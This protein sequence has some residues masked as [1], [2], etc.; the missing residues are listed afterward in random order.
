MLKWICAALATLTLI[1][2][3]GLLACY[4]NRGWISFQNA[5]YLAT[6]LEAIA[7]SFT[8]V[9]I[10]QQLVSQ[11]K[12]L[13]FQ[14]Q[15]AKASNSQSFVHQSSSFMLTIVENHDLAELWR[16]GGAQFETLDASQKMKFKRLVDWWLTFYENVHYQHSC[17]LLDP[18]IFESWENDLKLFIERRQI[19]NVWAD[20]RGS[21]HESF[22]AYVEDFL[23]LEK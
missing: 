2:F 21:Y 22:V 17:D 1:L 9:L 19:T 4:F 20:L 16:V 8:F 11:N 7:V 12:N 6:I 15:L 18:N 10:A 14:N 23:K 13:E 3:A 5:A